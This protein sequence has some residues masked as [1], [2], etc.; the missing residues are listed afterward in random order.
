MWSEVA[1]PMHT[2]RAVLF[3]FLS[4]IFGLRSAAGD[5]REPLL[6]S[7]ARGRVIGAKIK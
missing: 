1:T 7:L 3:S 2:A 6:A 4:F 5:V